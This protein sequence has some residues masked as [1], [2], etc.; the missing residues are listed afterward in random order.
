MSYS[1]DDLRMLRDKTG[2]GIMDCKNA[3]DESA[4]DIEKAV[5]ILRKKGIKVAQKKS[6]RIAK[7]GIIEGYIHT[8]SKLGVLVELNCETDFVARNQEFKELAHNLALQIAA[9]SPAYISR[10]NVPED[11]LAKEKEILK[12][13]FKGKPE[14]ILD[15]IVNGKMEDF[16][17]ENCLL[18]QAFV[19]DEDKKIKDL[20]S[21]KIA[22]FGENIVVK[23]FVRFSLGEQS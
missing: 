2:A 9:K 19:K 15:K 5:E 8:G 22:K 14:H 4:G 10:D 6:G 21:D 12:E 13:Q 1:K 18:D 16:Y 3:L 20:I 17:K 23:R 11:V 7:E